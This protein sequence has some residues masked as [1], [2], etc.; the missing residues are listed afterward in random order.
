MFTDGL[1]Q[2]FLSYAVWTITP[3]VYC[4]D[5]A[6]PLIFNM[7]T[8]ITQPP[9]FCTHNEGASVFLPCLTTQDTC[10]SKI[11]LSPNHLT[12]RSGPM[13][14]CNEGRRML[15]EKRSALFEKNSPLWLWCG[16]M[17]VSIYLPMYNYTSSTTR[18]FI[19][20]VF[21]ARPRNVY[22]VQ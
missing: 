2:S 1:T 16:A 12:T 7:T 22:R 14:A 3:N 9:V 10:M 19:A 13:W 21:V 17:H 4:W 11:Y 6:I 20:T 5:L 18:V 8:H 15:R